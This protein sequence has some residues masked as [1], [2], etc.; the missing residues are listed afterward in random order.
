MK[1]PQKGGGYDLDWFGQEVRVM[2]KQGPSPDRPYVRMSLGY[3][4]DGNEMFA[5]VHIEEFKRRRIR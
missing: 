4:E 1:S 3:D 5:S 2:V